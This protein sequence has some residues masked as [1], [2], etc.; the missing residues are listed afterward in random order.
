M[1]QNR[2]TLIENDDEFQ[3]IIKEL[4]ENDTVQ[5]MKKFKQHYE[6]TCFEHCLNSSLLLLFNL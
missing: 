5:Q 6:T 2:N 4:I 1:K 3:S